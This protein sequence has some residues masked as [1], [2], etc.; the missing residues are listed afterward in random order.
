MQRLLHTGLGLVLAVFLTVLSYAAES[1]L[2]NT[3]SGVYQVEGINPG[4]S[5]YRGTCTIVHN[6][7]G[8]YGFTWKIGTDTFEGT[9]ILSDDVLTV[10]WG[11]P[12]PVVYTVS[13]DGKRLDGTWKINEGEGSEILTR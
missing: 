10:D 1:S 6:E 7:S 9:G 5:T 3:I 13:T 8:S 4:G 2:A 12:D 11:Q